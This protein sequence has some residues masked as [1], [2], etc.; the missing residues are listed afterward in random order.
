MFFATHGKLQNSC[1]K[2]AKGCSLY[3]SVLK[4]RFF[5]QIRVLICLQFTFSWSQY[6]FLFGCILLCCNVFFV[7]SCFVL[8]AQLFEPLGNWFG[9]LV[10]FDHRRL[11]RSKWQE[12]DIVDLILCMSLMLLMLTWVATLTALRVMV[13]TMLIRLLMTC[14]HFECPPWCRTL[15][16]A[17]PSHCRPCERPSEE[18]L[19]HV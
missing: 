7:I 18:P 3:F 5:V 1:F 4:T 11:W 12:I 17:S 19:I 16:T 9:W 13:M 10:S 2:K 15:W 14:L 8:F 6:H